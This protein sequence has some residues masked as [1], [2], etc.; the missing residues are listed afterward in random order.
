M[1]P[2]LIS[3]GSVQRET[4]P[5]GLFL[6]HITTQYPHHGALAMR[7]RD[8]PFAFVSRGQIIHQV[9]K[10]VVR[11]DVSKAFVVRAV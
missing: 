2:V 4:L 8:C 7:C 9:S 3:L 11:R 10:S 5:R 1:F 6:G